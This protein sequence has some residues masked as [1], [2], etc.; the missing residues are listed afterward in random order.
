M[1]NG[2]QELGGVCLLQEGKK[3]T[4]ALEDLKW[5]QIFSMLHAVLPSL[6][7]IINLRQSA[8]LITDNDLKFDKTKIK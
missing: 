8:L 3:M 7:L 5:L 4:C 2:T 6:L 1:P